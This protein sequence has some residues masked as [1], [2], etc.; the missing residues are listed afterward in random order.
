[1]KTF[2]TKKNNIERKWYI[3]DAKDVV[4]GRLAVKVADILRGKYKPIFSPAVDCGDYV[5]VVNADK[6]KVTGGKE[7]KK[8][9]H[10]H[11]GYPGGI[12]SFTFQEMIEKDSRKI[13]EKAVKGMLPKNRLS[14]E[15]IKKLK[16]F[17]EADHSH[18]AQK[19]ESININ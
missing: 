18:E 16:V 1:M 4:L 11:S 5:I 2:V 3:V 12:R 15:M 13:I 14:S 8:I 10:R 6:V 19:P 9:Y 7:E 17:K